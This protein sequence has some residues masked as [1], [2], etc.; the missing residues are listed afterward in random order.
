MKFNIFFNKSLTFIS[1]YAILYTER[2]KRY[3]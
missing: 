3:E 2:G 1:I